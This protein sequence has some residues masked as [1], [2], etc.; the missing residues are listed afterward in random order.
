MT[1]SRP[2]RPVLPS[3]AIV[4]VLITK[5]SNG[6]VH[7]NTTYEDGQVTDTTYFLPGKGTGG[8]D[9]GVRIYPMPEA[10]KSPGAANEQNKENN[11]VI[12]SLVKNAVE[13]MQAGMDVAAPGSKDETVITMRDGRKIITVQRSE[14][15]DDAAWAAKSNDSFSPV[16]KADGMIFKDGKWVAE[17]QEIKLD[18]FGA[19]AAEQMGDA[20]RAIAA[21]FAQG[22]WESMVKLSSALQDLELEEREAPEVPLAKADRADPVRTS[23]N[24]QAELARLAQRQQAIQSR[25]N[26]L[27]ENEPSEEGP[28]TGKIFRALLARAQTSEPT[29]D[30]DMGGAAGGEKQN[31]QQQNIAAIARNLS[32]LRQPVIPD[33]APGI[34]DAERLDIEL[35][36][37]FTPKSTGS[38][39]LLSRIRSST[40]RGLFLYNLRMIVANG[41]RKVGLFRDDGSMLKPG[42]VTGMTDLSLLRYIKYGGVEIKYLNNTQ[43]IT[44]TTPIPP[45]KKTSFDAIEL[46]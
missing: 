2:K 41:N 43:A 3:K 45:K 16:F 13:E 38:A 19:S 44:P 15:E 35:Q 8:Q 31:T 34:T 28:V 17:D 20:M 25:I 14:W 46:D 4:Q 36:D 9:S 18:N 26:N 7:A 10:P 27:W 37:D 1:R 22:P 11:K 32:A 39:E 42:D 23:R 12:N 24:T 30:K 40:Q 6:F 33:E 5:D 29:E 21:S